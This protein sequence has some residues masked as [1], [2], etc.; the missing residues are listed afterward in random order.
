MPVYGICFVDSATAE[1]SMCHLRDDQDRTLFQTLIMQTRPREIVFEKGGL[2]QEA[3]RVLKNNVKNLILNAV[4]SGKEFP[5]AEGA[6]DEININGY[7]VDKGGRGMQ[8]GF[9][10]FLIINRVSI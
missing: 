2:S 10:C 5:D 4:Q 8:G 7:F 3:L 9:Q 1:F 6:M